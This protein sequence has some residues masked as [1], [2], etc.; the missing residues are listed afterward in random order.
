MTFE[1]KIM[2]E[3][4]AKSYVSK[5]SAVALSLSLALPAY[6]QD[7]RAKETSVQELKIDAPTKERKWDYDLSVETKEKGILKIFLQKREYEIE[8]QKYEIIT[9][10][11]RVLYKKRSET[12]AY[13]GLYSMMPSGMITGFGLLFTGMDE[14]SEE[15]TGQIIMG[16]TGLA[17]GGLSAL[18][19]SQTIETKR[20]ETVELNRKIERRVESKYSLDTVSGGSATV[21][22]ELINYIEQQ[23]ADGYDVLKIHEALLKSG[24]SDDTAEKALKQATTNPTATI[25]LQIQ[26][27]AFTVNGQYTANV[28]TDEN[29]HA[30]LQLEPIKP[31]FAFSVDELANTDVAKQL[32]KAGI[33]Q[34]KYLPLLEQ[35]AV[36]ISYD[37]VI[38]TKATDG[39]NATETV[40]VSGYEIS[41]K[42]LEG[43]IMGL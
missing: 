18:Y 43:I 8:Y 5:I 15:Y 19:F 29:G 1:E 4:I 34:Q 7:W 38:E 24:Y 20:H 2:L 22:L 11:E 41:Q 28:T 6:A 27:T 23:L 25:N 36:P 42:A 3:K 9:R 14:P 35:A 31:N 17:V 12:L 37:V 39:E 13:V 33:P 32:K 40:H 21:Q 16:L 30:T 26:A 10:Q